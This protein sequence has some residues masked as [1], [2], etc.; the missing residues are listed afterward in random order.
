MMANRELG[1]LIYFDE[2]RRQVTIREYIDEMRPFSDTLSVEDW[3]IPTGQY[4]LSLLTFSGETIDYMALASR[5]NRVATAK[6]RVEFSEYVDLQGIPLQT[7]ESRLNARI[8][9]Y[10]INTSSGSG[11]L[12]PPAT[13]S[14]LLE[15]IRSERPDLDAE[16]DRL[17]SLSLYSGVRFGGEA[18]DI[19][20]QERDALGVSLDIFS[21]NNKLRKRVLGGWSPPED[22]VTDFRADMENV[23][24]AAML[25]DL[26]PNRQS[27][28]QGISERYHK[29]E[30]AEQQNLFI[31]EESAIQHDLFNWPEMTVK[32]ISGRSVF[33]QGDRRLEVTYANRNSLEKTLGVDLV[34]FNQPFGQFVLV[35]YKL[36]S[37]ES[38]AMM[39]RPDEQLRKELERMDT[40]FHSLRIDTEIQAHEEYRLSEDGFVLKLVPNQG[41]QPASGELI[42]GMYIP[43]Q[44][45]H[46]L[47]GKNGPKGPNGG[48]QITFE[49]APRYL[50]N[51]QFAD[52]VRSGWIGTRGVQSDQLH[53]VIRQYYETGKAVMVA[54]ASK[55][56]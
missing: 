5:G 7:L 51:T 40:V 38:T 35:Q 33:G 12:F 49:N 30:P 37:K 1:L 44:Y 20:L 31:Q 13:W 16:I 48:I 56:E 53:E 42:P 54:I 14:A 18:A 10:F 27:F 55:I 15:T 23:H 22:S 29:E 39:Y 3:P 8:R 46:F 34:Y 4:I 9:R 21:G 19:L 41:L 52:S 50:N 17:L 24:L 32:H 43:R 28:L 45:M 26:P 47:L 36:M 11:G 25:T 2:E 6:Y